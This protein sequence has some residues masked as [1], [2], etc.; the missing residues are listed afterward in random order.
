MAQHTQAGWVGAEGERHAAASA[1]NGP[2][3]GRRKG[4]CA[5]GDCAGVRGPHVRTTIKDNLIRAN[6]LHPAPHGPLGH[7]T[8]LSHG[9]LIRFRRQGVALPLVFGPFPTSQAFQPEMNSVRA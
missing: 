9:Q 4:T 3:N 2:S 6:H 5:W 8:A 7:L 1:G